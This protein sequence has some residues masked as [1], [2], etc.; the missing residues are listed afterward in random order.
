[1]TKPSD[2]AQ[3]N[4]IR[5]CWTILSDTAGQ[6]YQTP[7]DN[8]IRHCWTILSDTA[9]QCYQTPLENGLIRRMSPLEIDQ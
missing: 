3:D 2:K 9:G 4:T 6:Y 7:L 1:M 8:T 5:H